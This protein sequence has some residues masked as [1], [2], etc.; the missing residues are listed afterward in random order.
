MATQFI[1]KMNKTEAGFHLLMTLSLVDGQIE[2]SESSIV[3]NFIEENFSDPIEIIKEQAF[4]RACPEEDRLQHFTET[5]QQFYSISTPEERN[6]LIEFAM[7]V[8]M[9][10]KKM[11]AN[12][13]QYINALYDCWG[14]D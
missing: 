10:D 13:N 5:A 11:E 3:L 14:L 1:S 8:V 6:K 2:S 9:A 7:K 4:I 12:E